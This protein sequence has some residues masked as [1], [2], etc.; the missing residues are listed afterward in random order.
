MLKQIT[1]A[2][3][4]SSML[5]GDQNV[6]TV[7]P[8]ELNRDITTV[9]GFFRTRTKLDEAIRDLMIPPFK[10]LSELVNPFQD[11]RDHL[12]QLI[13][14]DQEQHLYQ[15]AYRNVNVDRNNNILIELDGETT[16]EEKG[17][18]TTYRIQVQ[19]PGFNA[20]N[21]IS[22]SPRDVKMIQDRFP[23][24]DLSYFNIGGGK[25]IVMPRSLE[26]MLKSE[27]PKTREIAEYISTLSHPSIKIGLSRN[28]GPMEEFDFSE[29]KSNDQNLALL[30]I[31][32]IITGG[33]G[34]GKEIPNI[35]RSQPAISSALLKT[36]K[37]KESN[38]N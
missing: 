37:I 1:I 25:Y 32:H 18:T 31:S 14:S 35:V 26:R 3:H 34:Q 27:K 7:N 36:F 38:L 12:L 22:L 19:I 33:K 11:V 8:D 5:K 20:K 30:A 29:L 17:K 2:P 21:P 4:A 16:R 13:R 9:K 6:L 28:N 10:I 15:F 24:I 23:G